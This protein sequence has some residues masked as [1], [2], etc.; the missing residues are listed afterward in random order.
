MELKLRKLTVEV[1][2][3]GCTVG[4]I[5]IIMSAD[6]PEQPAAEEEPEVELASLSNIS[7]ESPDDLPRVFDI[8]SKLQWVLS[9]QFV[10]Y[11]DQISRF[12]TLRLRQQFM[13]E[14]TSPHNIQYLETM[15]W[16][17]LLVK[18]PIL[19]FKNRQHR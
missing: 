14:A 17:L 18:L 10:K 7:I 2:K 11:T 4:P 1:G 6:D 15:F 9:L 3:I 13:S 12:R 5:K 16:Y 19:A 8:P